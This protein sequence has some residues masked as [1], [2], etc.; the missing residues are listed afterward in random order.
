MGFQSYELFDQEF[1]VKMTPISRG[2][3]FLASNP[4]LQIFSATDTLKKG[5]HLL[6]GHHKQ[7]G[8]LQN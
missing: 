8:P 2:P 7:W 1:S 4:F 5:L 3:N 6:F